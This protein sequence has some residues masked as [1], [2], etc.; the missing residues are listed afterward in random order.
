MKHSRGPKRESEAARDRLKQ[1][2]APSA[3]VHH[4]LCADEGAA[5]YPGLRAHLRP[6][7][8][9]TSD[10][11]RR[12]APARRRPEAGA[13]SALRGRMLSSERADDTGSGSGDGDRPAPSSCI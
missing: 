3:C 12:R 11:G 7:Q 9:G 4:P 2:R 8:R 1:L 13:L 6:R 5:R 10:P